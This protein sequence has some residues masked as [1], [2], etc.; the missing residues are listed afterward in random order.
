MTVQLSISA[1]SINAFIS[2]KYTE[3]TCINSSK[4]VDNACTIDGH[5]YEVPIHNPRED[6][7]AVSDRT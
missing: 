3:E 7:E 6:S 2:Y 4:E 1:Y 5:R